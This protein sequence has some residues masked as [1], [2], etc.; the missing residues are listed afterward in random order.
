MV[1]VELEEWQWRYGEVDRFEIHLPGD[2]DRCLIK[3][4]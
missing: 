3:R 4:Q 2:N 1:A